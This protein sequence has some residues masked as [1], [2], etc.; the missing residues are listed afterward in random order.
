V[1][2]LPGP[3]SAASVGAPLAD[4]AAG[5][6]PDG[7]GTEPG[8]LGYERL[9][10]LD[11]RAESRLDDSSDGSATELGVAVKRASA[12]LKDSTMS[13]VPPAIGPAGIGPAFGEGNGM[14][15]SI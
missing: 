7:V 9:D 2:Q 12:C 8:H 15:W 6:A 14:G 10:G 3:A 1:A 4:I 11:P 13:S 5:V